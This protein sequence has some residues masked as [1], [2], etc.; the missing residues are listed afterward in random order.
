MRFNS[1]EGV[2]DYTL[3]LQNIVAAL[4]TVG[5]TIPPRRV[6]EKLL[7]TVPKS[8]RQVAVAIQVSA[9]LA[10]LTLEDATGRLRAAEEAE[11]EDDVAPPPGAD[12]KLLLTMEQWERARGGDGRKKKGGR[13]GGCDDSS[14]DDDGS[15]STSSGRGRS[16]YRGKCFDCGVRGHKARDCPKKKERAMLADV[17]EEAALL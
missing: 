13:S 2:D 16:R 15:S 11:A 5:E 17:E 12:G 3:R 10:T 9:N 7:R 14:D 1:G 8:L 6:V 4:E